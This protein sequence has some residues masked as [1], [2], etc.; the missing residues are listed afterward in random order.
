MMDRDKKLLMF[1]VEEMSKSSHVDNTTF[2][3]IKN[4]GLFFELR[5]WFIFS[6]INC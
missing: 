2:V 3:S 4:I 6:K 1:D 5:W